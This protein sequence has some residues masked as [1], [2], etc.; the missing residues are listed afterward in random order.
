MKSINELEA[1]KVWFKRKKESRLQKG[2]LKNWII[3]KQF[4]YFT[5]ILFLTTVLTLVYCKSGQE[6]PK[7][8]KA[9]SKTEDRSKKTTDST[10]TDNDEKKAGSGNNRTSKDGEKGGDEKNDPEK[11]DTKVKG[12][13]IAQ[14]DT[15]SKKTDKKKGS[16][17]KKEKPESKIGKKK[18]G[19]AGSGNKIKIIKKDP[20]KAS[21]EK[22]PI[23]DNEKSEYA[24]IP[25]DPDGNPRPLT[26]EEAVKLVIKHN[27]DVKMQQ[28]EILKSDTELKKDDS[29]YAPI[30][31]LRYQGMAQKNKMMGSTIFSGSKLYNDTLAASVKKLF[32]S[33]TYFEVEVSDNRFDSNAGEGV[34]YEGTLLAQLSQPPLHTGAL[35]VV[36]AQELLKN[37]FG[38]S[39]R[40]LRRIAR[41]NSAILREQLIYSLSQL[42]VKTMVDYWSLAIA[43]E[44]LKTAK[45]LLKNAKNIR[46]IT[47]RKRRIGLA[48]WFEVN[49]WNAVVAGSEASVKQAILQRN[50]ARRSILRT[51]NLRP[52]IKIT[53]ATKLLDT[54]PIDLDFK[55]DL[56]RALRTRPEIK[57]LKLQ[58]TNARMGLQLARNNL[59][60]SITLGG[61]FTHKDYGRYARTAYSEVPSGRFS[62]YAI[63]FKVEYP[64]W[65]E[66]AKVDVRNAKVSLRQLAIQER[67]LKRQIRDE[68]KEGHESIKI[69][70]EVLQKAIAA[71]KQTRSFYFGLLRRYRQGRFT[72]VA[73]KEALDA[74]ARS[75]QSLMQ[76]RINFNISIV[77]YELTR[78]NIFKK[79]DINI[80]RVLDK[81]KRTR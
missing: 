54:V 49:Q 50:N 63:E 60:P 11:R 40:K 46:A 57:N 3:M 42:I 81:M 69:A 38:I 79:Y 1:N 8:K 53:G 5:F 32:S 66:G 71:E 65:D 56:L 58:K 9:D 14:R 39:Q 33:G 4:R 29:K 25:L 41:N 16:V 55:K 72:A 6:K 24:T 34:Q 48:E 23:D 78:N 20:T 17:D 74:L 76:S 27:V 12:K 18:K 44:N 30:I 47:Y 2:S 80:N 26:L 73:V 45:M 15:E 52:D 22:S 67:R 35:K 31:G 13:K 43:E 36:L 61:S 7:G 70:H 68:I 62:E 21:I 19:H 59:L 77:R 28:L 37:S 51:L 75:R 64:L 10:T